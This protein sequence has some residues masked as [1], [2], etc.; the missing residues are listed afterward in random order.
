[1]AAKPLLDLVLTAVLARDGQGRGHDFRKDA[2]ALGET[3]AVHFSA[4]QPRDFQTARCQSYRHQPRD[5]A[6]E[7]E[8]HPRP[9]TVQAESAN[10]DERLELFSIESLHRVQGETFGDRG[11]VGRPEI[12]VSNLR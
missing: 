5:C 3:R 1:M 10:E 2:P 4:H 11:R 6:R 7:L 8:G 9:R 12:H